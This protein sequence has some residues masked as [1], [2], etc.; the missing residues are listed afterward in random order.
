MSNVCHKCGRQLMRYNILTESNCTQS[1]ACP[2][3]AGMQIQ[4]IKDANERVLEHRF[5]AQG[6]PKRFRS[7]TL[8]D[9]HMQFVGVDDV[10]S[11]ANGIYFIG[12]AGVGKSWLTVAWMRHFV[13]DGEKCLYI[14][15][16]DV[17]VKLRM[18]VKMYEEYK[19]RAEHYDYIFIDDFD[20]TCSY[21]YD[22]VYNFVNTLYNAPKITFFNSIELPTQN[23][24]AMRI[25]E[26]T[27]QVKLVTR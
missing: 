19:R 12:D 25:G 14:N 24:L 1:T 3:C 27:K 11:G 15:W 8:S 26:M 2:V 17:M 5:D 22:F 13:L 20:A 21:M 10:L 23:K 16:S 9:E 7:A 4:H 6:V 18:D